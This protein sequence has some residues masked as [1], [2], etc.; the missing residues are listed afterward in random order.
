MIALFMCGKKSRK[1]GARFWS[2]NLIMSLDRFVYGQLN[3]FF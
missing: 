1:N 3:D 2:V